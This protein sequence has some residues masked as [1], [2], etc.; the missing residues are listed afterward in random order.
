MHY[1]PPSNWQTPSPTVSSGKLFETKLLMWLRSLCC[2][3]LCRCCPV[4]LVLFSFPSCLSTSETE[5]LMSNINS[6]CHCH[7]IQKRVTQGELQVSESDSVKTF[8]FQCSGIFIKQVKNCFPI[9]NTRYLIHC[10]GFKKA[11]LKMDC[12]ATYTN[13]SC[14]LYDNENWKSN[15]FL[16][17]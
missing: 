8:S 12:N 15:A 11:T 9:F 17:F 6:F 1:N 10:F 2:L 4:I 7:Q 3:S 16:D 5:V 13:L 14:S